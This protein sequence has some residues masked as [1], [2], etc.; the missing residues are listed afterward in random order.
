MHARLA[1]VVGTCTNALLKVAVRSL[2]KNDARTFRDAM[3]A[4]R[5]GDCDH[6]SV[7]LCS[8]DR[9]VIPV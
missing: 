9:E 1:K 4:S 8:T 2:S 7:P 3:Q 5:L 6:E